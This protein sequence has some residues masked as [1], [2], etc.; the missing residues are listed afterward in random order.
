[1]AAG[2]GVFWYT[3]NSE[4]SSC[5]NPGGLGKCDNE[6]IL[7]LQR[8]IAMASTLGAGAAAITMALVGALTWNSEVP[9]K[10]STSAINCAV[11]PY[12]IT[13]AGAF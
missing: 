1:V 3:R 5:R 9:P 12:G 8:N 7:S 11:S 6:D 4:L 13:C 10:K 2:A